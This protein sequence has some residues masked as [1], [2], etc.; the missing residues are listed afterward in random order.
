[1]NDRI[2]YIHKISKLKYILSSFYVYFLF[3]YR[4]SRPVWYQ[5]N[6]HL[7]IELERRIL[8]IL[9]LHRPL[10]YTNL[11]EI[12]DRLLAKPSYTVF[13]ILLQIIF[14]KFC[15]PE[16]F[17]LA[18]CCSI[19]C[20]SVFCE[21]VASKRRAEFRLLDYYSHCHTVI[22][23]YQYQRFTKLWDIHSYYNKLL[24]IIFVIFILKP[25][26]SNRFSICSY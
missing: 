23:R 21:L 20:E 18:M 16:H 17:C 1:M 9:N 7:D 12:K 22:K 26:K 6:W 25:P 24:P 3:F 15:K 2:S 5:Q 13:N 11:Q 10:E 19:L 4:R 14:S 8:I